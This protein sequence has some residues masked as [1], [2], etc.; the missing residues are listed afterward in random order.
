M[1][2]TRLAAAILLGLASLSGSAEEPRRDD[3]QTL[4]DRIDQHVRRRWEAAGVTPSPLSDDAEYLRRASLHISGRIP[5]V[6]EARAFLD[7]PS[8]E[9][10]RRLVDELLDGPGY[11]THFAHVWR[12]ALLPEAGSDFQIRFLIPSFESWLRDTLAADTPYDQWVRELL[13]VPPASRSGTAGRRAGSSSPVAFFQ[14]KQN[15]PENLAAATS[16]MFLGV[17]IECAQCHD[18]P[19][20][21]W[22]RDQFWSFAA[23][24][25]GIERPAESSGIGAAVRELFDR[26]ELA[27]PDTDRVVQAAYL[28]GTEPQWK[29]KVGPRE[30]LADWVTA[31]ENRD[32]ARMA[33][34]RLWGHFFGVGLVDPLD[35]FS[36]RNP[37]S[38]PELLDELAVAFAAHNFDVKFLIR[39]ITASRAYQLSS[40]RTHDSQDDPRHFARMT[41]QALTPEELYHSLS[42][43][44]GLYE[45][46]NPQADFRFGGN[47]P[48]TELL[49]LF[50]NDSQPPT[51]R[52]TTILQALSL[53]NGQLIANATNL[54]Q[55]TTLAAV[56]DFPLMS[57]TE[58]LETL[59]LATITRLPRSEERERLL[60]YIES[61]GPAKDPKQ[62]LGDVF[63]ALLNSSEFLLNH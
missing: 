29:F 17:R 31:A 43:A 23:F 60:R 24:F 38:H 39:A 2:L 18:H 6:A 44:V 52:Q 62:A 5:T 35:D 51:E 57:D 36:D 47:D 32:F 7:D 45:P 3:V 25:A 15:K 28:D 59:Y 53:M 55:S 54:R 46:F 30:T 34:N 12:R 20:D 19:F 56:T 49:E 40:R 58:R 16:R 37:P 1:T 63:W 22:K 14:A 27:I 8:P 48:R 13:T 21:A 33:V 50:A 10:R 4:A 26:R 11:V 61:G 42:I 41:L 9:K